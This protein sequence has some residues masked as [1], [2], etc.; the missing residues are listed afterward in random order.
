VNK[1]KYS[2][3]ILHQYEYQIQYQ[4][5]WQYETF[6]ILRLTLSLWLKAL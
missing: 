3:N 1:L 6:K 5:V 2:L 4:Y